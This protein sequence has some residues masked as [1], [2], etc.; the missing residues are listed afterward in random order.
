L[1]NQA[2]QTSSRDR[3]VRLSASVN[4]PAVVGWTGRRG[5]ND[6]WQTGTEFGSLRVKIPF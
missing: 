1:V 4:H 2:N 6:N 3:F 5:S